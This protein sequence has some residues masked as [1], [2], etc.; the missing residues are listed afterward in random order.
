MP[1][2]MDVGMEK[3]EA[4]FTTTGVRKDS[5]KFFGLADGNASTAFSVAR[6]RSRRAKPSRPWSPCAAP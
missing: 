6:S 1:I 5:L 3:M 4:N 2:E